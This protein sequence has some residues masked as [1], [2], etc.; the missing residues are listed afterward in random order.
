M[1]IGSAEMHYTYR[2][3]FRA[4]SVDVYATLLVDM[5]RGDQTLF[6][7]AD[8]EEAAWSVLM[9]VLENWDEVPADDFPNYAAGSWGPEDADRLLAGDGRA[10]YCPPY[11]AGS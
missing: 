1:V 7:R 3:A 9:P 4:P 6:M 5:M 8:Q 11:R 10:W 2:E